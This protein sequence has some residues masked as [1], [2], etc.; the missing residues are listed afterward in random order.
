M[1]FRLP[2]ATNPL[3]ALF[4]LDH[5]AKFGT[6]QLVVTLQDARNS[7]RRV[8]AADT[9]VQSVAYI[10]VESNG[11]TSLISFERNR[12]H[13]GTPVHKILWNFGPAWEVI[14]I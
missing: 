1:A 10:I 12:E 8:F 5:L 4:D 2:A 6:R 3:R 9:G 11:M 13:G 7:A 14:K